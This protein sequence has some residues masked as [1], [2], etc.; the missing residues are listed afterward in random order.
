VKP[1]MPLGTRVTLRGAKA[2][3]TLKKFLGAID[4]TLNKK[5]IEDNHFSFGIKD[6]LEI[7][8]MEYERDIGIR[9]FNVTVVFE[10]AGVRVKRKK[11]KKGKL[12][13]RQH[14]TK[15]EIM[16]YMED[17]FKTKFE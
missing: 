14:V 6:Y 10:R 1:D 11:I 4:N 9:G 15:D 2:L 12:P 7:P 17:K 3:E 5:Q 8:G 13:K 16:K